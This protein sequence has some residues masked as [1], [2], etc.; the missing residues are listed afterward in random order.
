MDRLQQFESPKVRY[1]LTSESTEQTLEIGRRIG[2]LLPSGSVL[3]LE[4][5]L[6][7][8]KTLLVKGICAGLGVDSEVLS[9]SFILLEEYRGELPVLHFDLFRLD[10]MDDVMDVGLF[11]AIDGCNI[12]IVEWGDRLPQ[13]VL[14][15]DIRVTMRIT[16][17]ESREIFIEAYKNFLEALEEV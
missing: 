5:G 15:V 4:G 8:G 1:V 17:S 6:G 10:D 11:D 3:S 9:P 14:D 13:G 2:Q 7:V 12:V 16:G